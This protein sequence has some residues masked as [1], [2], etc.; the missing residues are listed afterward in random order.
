[1]QSK[2][3][4]SSHNSFAS[5]TLSFTSLIMAYSKVTS[6]FVAAKYFFKVGKSSFISEGALGMSLRRN[7]SLGACKETARFICGK[8]WANLSIPGRTP[9]VETVTLLEPMPKPSLQI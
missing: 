6:L 4:K 8:S 1:M 9:T 2:P 3:L 7:S 5:L